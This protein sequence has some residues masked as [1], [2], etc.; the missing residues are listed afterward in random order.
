[1][2]VV[3]KFQTP[4]IKVFK[5]EKDKTPLEFFRIS[6]FETWKA[7]QKDHKYITRYYKGLGGHKTEDFKKY[8]ANMDNYLYKFTKE[9]VEDDQ[10][11]DLCFA[12][13]K[14]KADARK[15]WLNIVD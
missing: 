3:Y 5:N 6:D 1:L 10:Y 7:K 4:L 8:L 2:G 13:G 14:G 15:E 9:S 12:Q 11:F